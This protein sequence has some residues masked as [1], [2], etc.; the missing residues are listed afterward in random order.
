MKL[1]N[2]K[3]PADDYIVT[4]RNGERLSKGDSLPKRL[5]DEGLAGDADLELLE[6]MG[7]VAKIPWPDPAPD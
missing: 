7:L 3:T 5:S 1:R 2:V 6:E 4:I